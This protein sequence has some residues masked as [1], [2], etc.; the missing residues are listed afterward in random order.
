MAHSA[1]S[2]MLAPIVCLLVVAAAG[3]SRP[4]VSPPAAATTPP[5]QVS[6]TPA[7]AEAKPAS[8]TPQ[9][10]EATVVP[11]AAPADPSAE[12][13][14]SAAAAALAAV[15]KTSSPDIGNLSV[16]SVEIARDS[17]GTWWAEVVVRSSRQDV[18]S[19]PVYLKRTGS[20]W[21]IVDMGTGVEPGSDDRF[22]SEVR[23]KL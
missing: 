9:A 18:D 5:S 10:A 20:S 21:A 15:K 12:V 2:S 17:S 6:T 16:D 14:K 8:T 4:P 11:P 13:R 22:P 23:D 19:L 7:P 3:C 1:R